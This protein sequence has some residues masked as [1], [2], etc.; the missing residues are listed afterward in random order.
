MVILIG[1]NQKQR[2]ETGPI[3]DVTVREIV[4]RIHAKVTEE[5]HKHFNLYFV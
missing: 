2:T 5:G 3:L 1:P 4:K